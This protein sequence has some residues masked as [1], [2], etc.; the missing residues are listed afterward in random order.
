MRLKDIL[1]LKVPNLFIIVSD[2]LRTERGEIFTG[3]QSLHVS[4]FKGHTFLDKDSMSPQAGYRNIDDDKVRIIGSNNN[5]IDNNLR[6][7]DAAAMM[8]RPR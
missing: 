2:N 7:Y 4:A 5:D 1:D 8:K 3:E 6:I